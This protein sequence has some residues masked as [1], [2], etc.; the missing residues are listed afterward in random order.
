MLGSDIKQKSFARTCYSRYLKNFKLSL[1][2]TL[3]FLSILHQT[4]SN[5]PFYWNMNSVNTVTIPNYTKCIPG[6]TIYVHSKSKWDAT[7]IK[8]EPRQCYTSHSTM[9][10]MTTI[11]IPTPPRSSHITVGMH[12]VQG[13][14]RGVKLGPAN[15]RRLECIWCKH[16]SSSKKKDNLNVFGV[17]CLSTLKAN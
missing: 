17:V 7:K 6:D 12:Q 13:S 5:S 15:R 14:N 16:Y 11:C 9:A 1:Y 3:K 10:R 4:H 2:F 8:L